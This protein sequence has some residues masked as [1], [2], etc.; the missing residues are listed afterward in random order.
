[1]PVITAWVGENPAAPLPTAVYGCVLLMSGVAWLV[2]QR[3]L[4][5]CNGGRD[6]KL[7]QAIGR[8][9][10]GKI[11]ALGYVTAVGLAFVATWLSEGACTCVEPGAPQPPCPPSP[12]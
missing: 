12:P 1:V 6:S 7:A 2:L 9:L 8:D 11:S 4:I 10:K 3:A 5:V